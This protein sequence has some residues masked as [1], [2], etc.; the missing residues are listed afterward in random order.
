MRFWKRFWI[1]II[2]TLLVVNLDPTA[3]AA[4][5][6]PHTPLNP[7]VVSEQAL[8]VSSP[9]Q[10]F[11]SDLQTASF[12]L[13]VLP[14]LKAV[15]VVGPID[16]D[17][18]PWTQEEKASMDL[19]A[20]ELQANGVTVYKFY[21]PNN[22]WDQIKSAALGAHFLLYRGHGVYWGDA[23]FPSNVGGFSLK[24]GIISPDTLRADLH[25]APNAIV[26][27][28]GCYTA[29]SSSADS[30]RLTSAEAQR[31]VVL[32]AQ[33]FV[34]N[35]TAGYFANWFDSAFQMFIR[36]LFQGQTLG[37]AYEAYFDFNAATVERYLHPSIS[38]YSLWLDKDEWYDPTP[39]YNNAFIG[40]PS[41]T[42]SDLF[43][44]PS[45]EIT[46]D[47]INSL[48]EPLSAPLSF[49]VQINTSISDLIWTAVVSPTVS[50]IAAPSQGTASDPIQI[51]LTPPQ[52][53]GLY[54][55]TITLQAESTTAS[56]VE[57]VIPVTL[58]VVDEIQ[59]IYLPGVI[60]TR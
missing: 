58:H 27:L 59:W 32:Y 18:G 17:Y 16:G 20:A 38:G 12:D 21:T 31:R 48:A 42:L 19:A 24:D 7:P 37:Q 36:Y 35:G 15:L 33:P 50:W 46:P 10:L 14:P 45:V 54:Q 25:L 3:L 41:A 23:G 43:A 9:E 26:M 34:Q 4:S 56:P 5:P 11:A 1:A 2:A 40:I 29:G 8:P 13:S 28:Y 30:I 44:S 52:S 6:D 22:N 47:V 53:P 60:R 49:A 51:T 57:L 55:A 39:Q